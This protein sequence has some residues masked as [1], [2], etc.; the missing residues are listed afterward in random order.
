MKEYNKITID[1][2]VLRE[3]MKVWARVYTGRSGWMMSGGGNEQLV[4]SLPLERRIILENPEEEWGYSEGLDVIELLEV[5]ETLCKED[6]DFKLEFFNGKTE[7]EN[8]LLDL[9]TREASLKQKLIDITKELEDIPQKRAELKDNEGIGSK[10]RKF[11]PS[12]RKA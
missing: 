9:K 6:L 5:L 10:I 11:F 7:V 1:I 2:D 12:G 3:R 4:L 8:R